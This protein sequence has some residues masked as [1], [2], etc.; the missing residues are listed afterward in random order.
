MKRLNM[1]L[2]AKGEHLEDHNS[3]PHSRLR[4]ME[5]NKSLCSLSEAF[6]ESLLLGVGGEALK[7]RCKMYGL[8]INPV[9]MS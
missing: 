2:G 1:V 3:L 8:K 4:K 6:A 7:L 5:V 9:K